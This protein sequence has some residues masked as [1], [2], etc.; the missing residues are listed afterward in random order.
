ML[1]RLVVIVVALEIEHIA[2]QFVLGLC[3]FRFLL[4]YISIALFLEFF[5]FIAIVV[6]ACLLPVLLPI[7]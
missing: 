3:Y 1:L 4:Y 2:V 5:V 6:S 7:A